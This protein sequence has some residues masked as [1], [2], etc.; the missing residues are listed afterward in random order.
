MHKQYMFRTFFD[1]TLTREDANLASR[2]QGLQKYIIENQCLRGKNWALNNLYIV[3]YSSSMWKYSTV[4]VTQFQIIQLITTGTY[5]TS[6]SKP[7]TNIYPFSFHGKQV[8]RLIRHYY[9]LIML[10]KCTVL[11]AEFIRWIIL[12]HKMRF[13]ATNTLCIVNVPFFRVLLR[14]S[15]RGQ[16]RHARMFW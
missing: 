13:C 11:R 12:F 7:F 5:I 4:A 10:F 8:T 9:D 16:P 6:S 3:I 1:F 15:A 14:K 2:A